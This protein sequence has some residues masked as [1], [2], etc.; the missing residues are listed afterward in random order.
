MSRTE[1]RTP[2]TDNPPTSPGESPDGAAAPGAAAHAFPGAEVWNDLLRGQIERMQAWSAELARV[3]ANLLERMRTSA[4][5]LH[6]ALN[7]SI[8]HAANLSA[9]F[10]K[11]A[12]DA[13][14]RAGGANN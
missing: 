4:A 12:L 11:L 14:R 5:D 2:A 9:E 1:T 3:E 8:D 10:R 7:D 6:R 13:L